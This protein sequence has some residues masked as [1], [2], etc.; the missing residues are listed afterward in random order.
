M[1]LR[2]I[3]CLALSACAAVTVSAEQPDIVN[4]K[5]ETRSAASGLERVF[6]AVVEAA[7][8]AAWIAYGVPIVPGNHNLCCYDSYDD[9]PATVRNCGSCRLEGESSYEVGSRLSRRVEL[10]GPQRLGV[11]FRVAQ[12][13]L[14]KI[15]MFSDDCQLDAGGLLLYWLTEV[16]AAESVDLLSSLVGGKGRE[17]EVG[18]HLSRSALAAIALTDDPSADRALGGFVAFNQPESLRAA[19]TFWLGEAR[20]RPGFELLRRV[21]REDPSEHVRKQ[22]AFG[23]YASKQ[24]EA[25]QVLIDL[26]HDDTNVAVRGQALFWLAQKAG[27][28]AARAIV[29]TI[30]EDPETEVKKRAVFALT[31]LPP[32]EGIPLLIRVARTN[33]N[34]EVRRQAIFWLGQ[35]KDPRALAFIEEMLTH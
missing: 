9:P 12:K 21:A 8:D 23:L 33:R 16:R 30:A 14:L 3:L 17:E 35:S 31:Q 22:A 11:F 15:R 6:R 34:R 29:E 27:E 20:G 1:R 19:V 32:D 28:K 18:G 24:P 7:P 13:R 4:A 2:I 5:V 25:L 10:E 26:A